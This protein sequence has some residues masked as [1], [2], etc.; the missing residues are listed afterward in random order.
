MID[1]MLAAILTASASSSVAACPA[2]GETGSD[3]LFDVCH[4]AAQDGPAY[5]AT[6]S[7]SLSP[8]PSHQQVTLFKADGTWTVRAAGYK[9]KPGGAFE[10]RRNEFA[11]SDEDARALVGRLD[12]ETRERLSNLTYY[13]APT[14]IC[15]DGARTEI[16]VASG[17]QRHSFAQHSCAGKTE[18]HEVAEAFRKVVLKY[19]PLFD[20]MLDGL[21]A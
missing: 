17:G 9:W 4:P 2:D 7:A 15:T 8:Q 11:I 19:D 20:G 21:T 3:H 5:S 10:T 12:D 16:A 14:V 18:L 6:F 1:L 13:G